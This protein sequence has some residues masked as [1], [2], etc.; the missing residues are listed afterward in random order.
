MNFIPATLG[1]L[2]YQNKV[3]MLHRNKK[4]RD[5]HAGKYNGIG[6]KFLGHESAHECMVRE[7]FEETGIR[8]TEKDFQLRGIIFFPEFDLQQR[9][10]HVYVFTAQLKT[11][12]LPEHDCLE[13]TLEWV[14]VDKVLELNLW[15]SDYLFLPKVLNSDLFFQ[16]KMTYVDG[17]L[18]H[19]I[20]YE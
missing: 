11:D 2:R 9:N 4:N 8:L 18:S 12:Q 13:G 10:W 5:L 19:H 6:G 15:E 16:A 14:S 17:K 1:Y 3:L 7:C 20:F